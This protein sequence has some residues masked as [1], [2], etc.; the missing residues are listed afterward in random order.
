ME[1]LRVK[2]VRNMRPSGTVPLTYMDK[3][4]IYKGPRAEDSVA[5]VSIQAD[6]ISMPVEKLL[7]ATVL[8]ERK[9]MSVNPVAGRLRFEPQLDTQDLKLTGVELIKER[10]VREVKDLREEGK[11]QILGDGRNVI[12]VD[13]NSGEI[14]T[15]D[16]YN[17]LQWSIPPTD[18][19]NTQ[20]R[21]RRRNEGIEA[22][23]QAADEALISPEEKSRVRGQAKDD[24]SPEDKQRARA[25][26][27][28]GS[29]SSVPLSH[30][31]GVIQK[32]R[33]F[34]ARIRVKGELMYL[35]SF[36]TA[37]N[38]ARAYDVAA[39][40]FHDKPKVNFDDH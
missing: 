4:N 1:E 34:Q 15:R 21:K 29:E 7:D 10:V 27:A 14:L 35:G 12:K 5:N 8:V 28:R 9:V 30:F 19:V 3:W 31:R 40:R 23:Q 26:D 18:S 38:A 25:Q 20:R 39:R 16:V 37:T 36:N 6:A 17:N 11:M 13:R 33:R 32:G 24:I 22:L 2:V